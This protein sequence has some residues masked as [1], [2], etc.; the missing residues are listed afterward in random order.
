MAAGSSALEGDT[1]RLD[2]TSLP[3]DTDYGK[4]QA[5]PHLAVWVFVPHGGNGCLA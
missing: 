1:P 2:L 3:R 4:E 5:P